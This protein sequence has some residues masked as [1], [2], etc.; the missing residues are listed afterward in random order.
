M[1]EHIPTTEE[2]SKGFAVVP[3]GSFIRM[4]TCGREGKSCAPRKPMSES[5]W[6]KQVQGEWEETGGNRIILCLL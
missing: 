3:D 4:S 5:F 6:R 2:K 1:K